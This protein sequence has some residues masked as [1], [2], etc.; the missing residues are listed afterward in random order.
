VKKIY[1]AIVTGENIQTN[2]EY[3]HYMEPSPR[4]PKNVST[5][6]VAGWAKC[7]LTVLQTKKIADNL[8]KVHIHLETGRTHQIRAQMAAI[9]HP[10]VADKI[11]GG[12]DHPHFPQLFLQSAELTFPEGNFTV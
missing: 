2:T 4:A 12:A 5:Q 1:R 8:T 3:V 11:Y 7:I 9:G 6:P 10:L